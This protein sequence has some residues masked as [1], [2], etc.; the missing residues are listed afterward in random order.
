MRKFCLTLWLGLLA[1]LPSATPALADVRLP[2]FMG[3][4]MVLQRDMPIPVWGWADAGEAVTVKLG[5]ATAKTTANDN[6]EWRVEL[7]KRDAGGPLTLTVT[8][9]NSVS[10]KDILIGE[11]WL[12]SGQS[13]MEWIVQRSSNPE[14]EIANANHPQIRQIKIN[15]APTQDAQ[16]DATGTWLVCSPETVAGFTAAGYFMGRELQKELNVPIGLINSSWGGTRIEPWTPPEG[17]AAVEELKDLS[18]QVQR[19][20]PS[21]TEYKKQVADYLKKLEQ[22]TDKAK[23]AAQQGKA[24]PPIVPLP[25]DLQP[26][27][28][29]GHPTALYNGMLHPFVGWPIRGA[30]WYQGE[31]NASEGMLYRAKMEALIEGWRKV[32]G[33]GDFPVYFVQIAP[34]QYG[35]AHHEVLPRL[36][37]AQAATVDTVKNTGMIVINDIATINDIHP[38]NKQDVGKRLALLALKRTYGKTDLVDTGATFKSLTQRNNN[39]VLTFENT[40]GELKSRDGKPLTGFEIIG[41]EAVWKKATAKIDGDRIILSAEGVTLPTAVRFAWHKTA[42]PNLMNGA[43]LPT[44]AFRAGDVPKVD[45]LSSVE[46]AA[47]YRLVYELDL[48]K[49]SSAIKYDVDNH[50][51][52]GKF[53]RIAYLLETQ[54]PDASPEFVFVSLDAFT[55]DAKKIGIPTV[56]S[57]ALFQQP[58][59]N[60]TVVSNVQGITNG[61]G[62]DGVNI[63]FWPHNYGPPNSANVP[64]A[65]PTKFDFGDQYS[66]PENGYGSMQIHSFKN[67]VTLFAINNWKSGPNADIGIGNSTGETADWTFTKSSGNLAEKRLRVFVRPVAN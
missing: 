24:I 15:R 7:P 38:P 10:L 57:K 61:V 43:G 39:L 64:G 19:R 9:K 8:G 67:K 37:E 41:Q 48:S 51:S 2:K 21:S 4:H 40:A 18:A 23:E 13:N 32:W 47:N 3:D 58:V 59:K 20:T 65:S 11:V 36:W 35:N 55:N 1:I 34:Y 60:V 44:G 53:D 62:Q 28:S 42:E 54:K 27:A 56:E 33:I 66:V 63:E 49:L 52:V 6:G 25:E 45:P 50:Q 17:F 29:S 26:Q 5:D 31:S 16:S 14:T 22:W 46:E 12:C 30:I